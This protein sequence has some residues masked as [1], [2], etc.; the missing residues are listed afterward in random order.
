MTG[1]QITYNEKRDYLLNILTQKPISYADGFKVEVLWFIENNFQA[2][3]VIPFLVSLKTKLD[4][5][6]YIDRI[7]GRIV[8][9]EDEDSASDIIAE[10]ILDF[11]S[12]IK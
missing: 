12:F 4:I 10:Y 6:N 7:T 9:R 5:K 11:E 1:H 3:E 2:N 8:Y